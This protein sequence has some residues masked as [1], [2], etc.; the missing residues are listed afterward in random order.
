MNVKSYF[1]GN[2]VSLIA[3][4]LIL[5][6]LVEL[7][8]FGIKFALVPLGAAQLTAIWILAFPA[9]FF[10]SESRVNHSL[11][12]KV[13]SVLAVALT[14]VGLIL[15]WEGKFLGLEL[16]LLGYLFE[17]LAGIPLYLEVRNHKVWSNLF[18]WGAVAFTAGLPLY[19][20]HFAWL[21]VIGD[22]V[23]MAGLIGLMAIQWN[24]IRTSNITY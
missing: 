4:V 16:I 12:F 13:T 15:T 19:L 3:A 14:F 5:T 1:R 22:A 2:V 7:D 24:V 20:V 21:A 11:F 23:K 17:P 9:V 18:F 10:Y 6:L 8:V